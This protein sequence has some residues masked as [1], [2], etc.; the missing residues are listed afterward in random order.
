VLVL[1]SNKR[2]A[3][4]VDLDIQ[5]TSEAFSRSMGPDMAMLDAYF[6]CVICCQLPNRRGVVTDDAGVTHDGAALFST[7][8]KKLKAR[9]G[10]LW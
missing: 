8:I 5:R 6:S 4:E 7:Q 10:R 3:D 2:T 9:G 1:V